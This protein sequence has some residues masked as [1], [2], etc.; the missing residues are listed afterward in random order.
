M[1]TSYPTVNQSNLELTPM[2]VF[3]TPHAAPYVNCTT[4]VATP[5][6]VVATA[7]GLVAGNTVKF[8]TTGLLPTGLVAGVTYFVISAGLT[9]SNFEVSATLAGSAI[10]FT[11]ST[12][13]QSSFSLQYAEIDLGGSLGNVTISAKYTKADLKADQYG[14]T[15]LDRRVKGIEVTAST[16][17]AEV[18]NFDIWKVVFPHI[19]ELTTGGSAVVMASQIGDSDSSHTGLLRLHPMSVAETDLNFDYN[20][21]KTCASAESSIVYGPSEQNR[22]KIVWN[23][24]PDFS[25]VPAQFFRF[26]SL[27][28]S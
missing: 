3:W 13:G 11:G 27:A 25:T 18:L 5:G 14:E 4:A 1:A 26:G 19:T 15:V 20:F 24:L 17:L 22:L 8:A 7:H 12:S 23:I 2:Q 10:N 9:S 6:V 16:E 28:A 21:F